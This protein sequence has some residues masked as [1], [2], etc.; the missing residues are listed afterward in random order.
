M[1]KV[2]QK[3][4]NIVHTLYFGFRSRQYKVTQMLVFPASERNK[5]A[6]V[7][8]LK[9]YLPD[10]K[11]ETKYFVLE[12]ASGSGQHV[13]YFASKFPNCRWQPSEISSRCL[14][15]INA[16]IKSLGVKNVL[17]P[18]EIDVSLP[19]SQWKDNTLITS[20]VDMMLCVNMIHIT[21][22]QCT[23]GLFNSA[24]VLLKSGG[25]LIMYGPYA[26]D[27]QLTPESNVHFDRSLRQE[28]VEYGV[29]DIRD[30]EKLAKDNK[31]ALEKVYDMPSN[32]KTLVFRK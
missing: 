2:L 20:S 21:P 15:S 25:V 11:N 22:W 24:G 4:F 18:M 1:L 5:D 17:P 14:H 6:I 26:I 19:V 3:R 9:H 32:N 28:N 23:I 8:V 29:R 27:G 12:V 30:L 31:M 7:N 10:S 13:S 16:Y